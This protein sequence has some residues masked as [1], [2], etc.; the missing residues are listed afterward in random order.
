MHGMLELIA[1]IL[2]LVTDQIPVP[3]TSAPLICTA[4]IFLSIRVLLL[5]YWI[6]CAK[7][8]HTTGEVL[9]KIIHRTTLCRQD[10]GEKSGYCVTKETH[11]RFAGLLSM[12]MMAHIFILIASERGVANWPTQSERFWDGNK[13]LNALEEFLVDFVVTGMASLC[14]ILLAWQFASLNARLVKQILPNVTIKAGRFDSFTRMHFEK[15]IP[16]ASRFD[17]LDRDLANK[18]VKPDWLASPFL[19]ETPF[20]W[21]IMLVDLHVFPHHPFSLYLVGGYILALVMYGP[22]L[23]GTSIFMDWRNDR[24]VAA[25]VRECKDAA[26]PAVRQAAEAK[27]AKLGPWAP[28]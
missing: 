8:N 26:D 6:I 24:W 10:G 27:L 25:L 17:K 7:V 14:V 5:P 13:D 28:K 20:L 3:P 1:E 11:K 12:V 9:P 16:H 19:I 22:I 21:G 23:S 15:N 2:R 18:T 4:M